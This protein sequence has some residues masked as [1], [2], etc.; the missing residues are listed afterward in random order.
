MHA[1][2]LGKITDVS[3]TDTMVSVTLRNGQVIDYAPKS[4]VRLL[5]GWMD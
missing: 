4:I 5:M 2:P 1:K 3:I